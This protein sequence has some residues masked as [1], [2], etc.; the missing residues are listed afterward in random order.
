[1]P[2]KI[3]PRY[4]TTETLD[5]VNT[6]LEAYEKPLTQYCE[7]L[8][9]WN[10]KVNLISR[11]TDLKTVEKHVL[12][13]LLLAAVG[14]FAKEKVLIDVGSGGGLPGIP[15]AICFPEKQFIL[16]DRVSRKCAAMNDIRAQLKL[17]NVEVVNQDAAMF[18]VKHDDFCWITKHAVKI[19]EFIP[20][21]IK[22][23][24]TRFYFL[25]GDDFAEEASQTD[26]SLKIL[27][28]PIDDYIE[29]PFFLGK[30]VLL[31]EAT[32]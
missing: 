2:Y 5:Y 32:P 29:D 31:I 11:N 20:Q 10:G 25:K 1:M 15:L 19:N 12:H 7:L 24:S 13:S 3:I 22:K 27:E 26:L 16:I 6:L 28:Y 4:F 21:V 30:R 8:L 18:H 17:K 9:W 14:R 23:G